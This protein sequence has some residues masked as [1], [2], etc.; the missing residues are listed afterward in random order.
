MPWQLLQQWWWKTTWISS[1]FLEVMFQ[2]WSTC[3][4]TLILA[5]LPCSKTCPGP[6]CS[7]LGQHL[8]LGGTQSPCTAPNLTTGTVPAGSGFHGFPNPLLPRQHSLPVYCSGLSRKEKLEERR[9]SQPGH[10][11]EN[12]ILRINSYQQ[13]HQA[14]PK[15]IGR[16]SVH[17]TEQWL[18]LLQK[19]RDRAGGSCQHNQTVVTL[20]RFRVGCCG[21]MW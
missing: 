18:L 6:A 13:Q 15:G 5:A 11:P 3:V 16:C 17:V 19:D 12:C 7:P 1:A 4:P 21:W 2:L 14:P 9:G 20:Q 8:R 10:A